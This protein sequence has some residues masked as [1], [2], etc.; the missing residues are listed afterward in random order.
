MLC[1]GFTMGL[2]DNKVRTERN[3]MGSGSSTAVGIFD[4]VGWGRVQVG[5]RDRGCGEYRGGGWPGACC[6]CW[7]RGLRG[8][9]STIVLEGKGVGPPTCILRI[10]GNGNRLS[11]YEFHITRGAFSN[12]KAF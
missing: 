4:S 12:P 8:R 5:D 9:A 11:E 7:V 2:A 6:I 1:N 10:C 3:G